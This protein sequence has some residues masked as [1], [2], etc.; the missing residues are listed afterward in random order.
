MISFYSALLLCISIAA[1]TAY[2][3][4]QRGRGPVAWFFVGFA[5]GLIGLLI[6]YLLPSKRKQAEPKAVT[7]PMREIHSEAAMPAENSNPYKEHLKR[8]PTNP[9]LQWYY[10]SLNLETLGPFKLD[11]LRKEFHEKKLDIQSYIWCEEFD[12]WMQIQE[13]QNHNIITDPDLLD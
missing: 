12:D 7:T 1:I 4:K 13:L 10:I 3:A 5:L 2:I 8:I 11:E 6:L 9:A